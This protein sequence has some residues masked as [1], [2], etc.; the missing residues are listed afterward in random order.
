MISQK[1]NQLIECKA[2]CLQEGLYLDISNDHMED[3]FDHDDND[4]KHDYQQGYNDD[5]DD[6]E[7]NKTYTRPITIVKS[8]KAFMVNH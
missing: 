6:D 4:K 1:F 3:D 5:D 8:L 7:A 2:A